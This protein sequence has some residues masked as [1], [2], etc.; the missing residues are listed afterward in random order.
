M[1][2]LFL[3]PQPFY[4]LRGMCIAQREILESLSRLGAEVDVL[5]FPFGEDLEIPGVRILRLPRLPWIADVPIGPSWAK[6][7]LDVVLLAFAARL[8]ATHWYPRVHACEESAFIA[9]LLKPLFGFE[10]LYDMDDILSLRVQRSGFLRW[11]PALRL[12]RR[13][14]RWMIRSADLVLT[15]SRETTRYAEA[16][17]G[18]ERVLFYHH[19]P[20]LP[21]LE[22]IPPDLERLLR[23]RCG[24]DHQRVILYAGNLEPY[25][26]VDLLLESLPEVFRLSPRTCCVVIGGEERQ[27]EALRAKSEALGVGRSISWLGKRPIPETLRY[28]QVADVLVSPMTQEKAVP[29]KL[30]AYMASGTPIVATDLPNHTSILDSAAGV[31]VPARP[32]ALA[33][34]LLK[35]LGDGRLRRRLGQEA[36]R[37]VSHMIRGN[38]TAQALR[39][40]YPVVGARP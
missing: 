20:H 10:L 34:G 37:R 8:C 11:R 32:E 39:K 26:G 31:L 23:D 7:A 2:I 12:L 4:R 27:I 29:M 18:P 15:N 5:T 25:Q 19:K 14:E 1:R 22:E 24:L 30:Y 33:Q 3:A 16:L 38:P 28:L 13:I 36:Q 35:V 21:E 9:A 17:A 40:A 6:L